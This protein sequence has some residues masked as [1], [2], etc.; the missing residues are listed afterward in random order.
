[1]LAAWAKG[2]EGNLFLLWSRKLTFDES[3]NK[4]QWSGLN[5]WPGTS[6]REQTSLLNTTPSSWEKKS[7]NSSWRPPNAV[8][9]PLFFW[10]WAKW[11]PKYV[12]T[13]VNN[14]HMIVGSCWFFYLHKEI[15]I[16]KA[17][18]NE[19]FLHSLHALH[20]NYSKCGGHNLV[21]GV[22]LRYLCFTQPSETLCLVQTQSPVS[23]SSLPED[24]HRRH[25]SET[26][27]TSLE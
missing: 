19:M 22:Y 3:M 10:R 12:Q 5:S 18:A 20:P 1:M 27:T 14:K 17:S 16:I 11:C 25:T 4:R 2:T 9:G 26:P 15:C 6:I 13:E 21:C 24:V 23:E 7:F 8:T